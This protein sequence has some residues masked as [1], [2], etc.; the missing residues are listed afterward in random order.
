MFAVNAVA[1]SWLEFTNAYSSIGWFFGYFTAPAASTAVGLLVGYN[2]AFWVVRQALHLH[3]PL[4]ALSASRISLISAT[5]SHS[6]E[7]AVIGAQFAALAYS[8]CFGCPFAVY[9]LQILLASVNFG[10][11]AANMHSILG[12]AKVG[13]RIYLQDYMRVVSL[14]TLLLL[15]AALYHIQVAA[16]AHP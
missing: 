9:K 12:Q 14:T 15:I 3:L 1:L 13:F 4:D 5:W 11:L 6:G 8:L 2:F 16:G 10:L 7:L